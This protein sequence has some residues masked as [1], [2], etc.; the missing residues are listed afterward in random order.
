MY[1]PIFKKKGTTAVLSASIQGPS[2]SPRLTCSPNPFNLGTRMTLWSDRNMPLTISVC[3]IRGQ[4][5]ADIA[6][7]RARAGFNHYFWDTRDNEK[8]AIAPGVYVVRSRSGRQCIERRI[9]LIR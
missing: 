3:N 7:G 2:G 4:K 5:V 6:Q 8:G 9:L 1:V